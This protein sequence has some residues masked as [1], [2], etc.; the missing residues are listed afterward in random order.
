[1]YFDEYHNYRRSSNVILRFGCRALRALRKR[2]FEYFVS[3]YYSF[4]A[5]DIAC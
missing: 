1:M 2:E 4:F 5:I 3:D